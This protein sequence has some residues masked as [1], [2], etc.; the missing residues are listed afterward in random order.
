MGPNQEN[1][2][3]PSSLQRR[4][5]TSLYS[6]GCLDLWHVPTYNGSKTNHYDA[7]FSEVN[8]GDLGA[9]P[10]GN[11]GGFVAPSTEAFWFDSNHWPNHLRLS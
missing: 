5:D 10:C 4:N 2:V 11:D 9:A 1:D 6:G 3:L 8:Y 7:I